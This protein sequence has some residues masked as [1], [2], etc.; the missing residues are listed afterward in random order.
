MSQIMIKKKTRFKYKLALIE[1][2]IR[3]I[4]YSIGLALMLLVL[5]DLTVTNF[6]LKIAFI[7]VVI[8]VIIMHLD[9]MKRLAESMKNQ[10]VTFNPF[11]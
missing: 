1:Y 10:K 8:V 2:I 4:M 11:K 5:Y 9:S 6:I 3:Y 7:L